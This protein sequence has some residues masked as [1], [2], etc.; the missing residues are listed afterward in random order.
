MPYQVL[1]TEKQR[2]LKK[3]QHKTS[4][5]IRNAP[6]WNQHLASASEAAVKVSTFAFTLFARLRTRT[7]VDGFAIG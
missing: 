6:G 4:S 5:P 2:N 3:I 1:E 7:D